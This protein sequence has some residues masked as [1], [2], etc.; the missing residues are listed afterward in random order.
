MSYAKVYRS[1]WDGTL[2]ERW[3]VWAV[4]VFLLAHASAKGLVDM[5]PGAISRRSCIPLE[6][7]QEALAVLEAEDPTSRS[8]ECQGRRIVRL[9]PHRDWGWRIVNHDYYRNLRDVENERER[10]AERVRKHRERRREAVTDVTLGNADVTLGNGLKLQA[11]AEADAEAK[12]IESKDTRTL[13]ADVI[14][15]LCVKHGASANQEHLAH[16]LAGKILKHSPWVDPRDLV[17]IV[18]HWLERRA[19]IENP[20]AYFAKGSE[21]FTLVECQVRLAREQAEHEDLKRAPPAN[22]VAGLL[23]DLARSKAITHG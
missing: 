5:T 14:H 17:G 15:D 3:E 8:A 2:A 13:S 6:K 22:A 9:D 4:W 7:V 1:L 19:A 20:F 23:A 18:S 12:K 11:E 16:A 21:G 10:V